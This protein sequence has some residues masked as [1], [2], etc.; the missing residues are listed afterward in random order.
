MLVRCPFQF[1]EVSIHSVIVRIRQTVFIALALPL[2]EVF[3]H[4]PHIVKQVANT[5]TIGLIA[6]LIL[7]G[8]HRLSQFTVL[9]PDKWVGRHVILRLRLSCLPL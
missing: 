9:T 5:N 8:F 7:I 2:M 3:M 1:F 6:K 4:L